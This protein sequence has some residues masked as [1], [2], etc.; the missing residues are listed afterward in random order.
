MDTERVTKDERNF[1][2]LSHIGSLFAPILAPL[3]VWLIKKE[4]SEFVE[5]H[6]KES[7]N[8]SISVSIYMLICLPLFFV[9]I[10]IP[11]FFVVWICFIIF[12]IQATMEAS[13]GDY[14]Q[15]PMIIRFVQ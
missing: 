4:E 13:K 7:L 11:L 8:A 9:L 2:L 15:Y 6:S 5:E 1:A 14:Y 12:T 10:G 3:V